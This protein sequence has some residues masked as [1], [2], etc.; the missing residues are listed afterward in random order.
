MCNSKH[1]RNNETTFAILVGI[2]NYAAVDD[3]GAL[4]GAV[5]DARLFKQY[6]TD[7][8][9]CGGLQVPNSHIQYLE[10][11]NATRSAII[12]TLDSH[13]LN[14]PA[15]LDHGDTTLIFYFAGHG[16]RVEAPGNI[17]AA[18]GKIEVLCP[19]DERT[20]GPDGEYVHGIPDYVLG[21]LLHRI[22]EKKGNNMSV[23]LDSCHSGGMGRLEDTVRN[24]KIASRPIP[25]ELD[26]HLWNDISTTRPYNVWSSSA[27]S[28]VLLAACSQDG[29]AYETSSEPFHGR[30]T[31][32]LVAELRRAPLENTTYADII[33]SLPLFSMQVPHCGGANRDRLLFRM[34][35]PVAGRR[36][37]ALTEQLSPSESG[38]NQKKTSFLVSIGSVEGVCPGTEFSVHNSDNRIL[39]T[40]TARI[41]NTNQT[42]LYVE[43]DK[44][45]EIPR[46]SR[47][48]VKDWKNNAKVLRVYSRD[49]E[50]SLAITGT[51]R[52]YVQANSRESANLSLK[53][54]GDE[55][56]VEWLTGPIVACARELRLPLKVEDIP[57]PLHLPSLLDGISHFHFFLERENGST[58]LPNFSLEMHRLLGRYP[59]RTPDRSV[60]AD[61]N[62][63]VGGKVEFTSNQDAEYGFTMRNTSNVD[64]FPYLFYFN[65]LKYTIKPW[66]IPESA[67]GRPPLHAFGSVAVG[68]GGEGAFSFTLPPGTRSSSGFVKMFVSTQYLSL[69]WIKQ[70]VPP[71]DPHFEGSGRLQ[72]ARDPET[73]FGWNALRVLLTMTQP[74]M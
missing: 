5:N 58:L 15:I 38:E 19:S 1:P 60:G 21:Q 2:N 51:P 72:M 70:P 3:F 61:G 23:I 68:L 16:S 22:A 28:H 43:D 39:C 45:V 17:L 53:R 11:G 71:F 57:R 10:N 41:V 63:I 42:V 49:F 34:A 30:F 24:V 8:R 48:L 14:N 74:E 47:A 73:H 13:F 54:E 25:F 36:A 32:S 62:L 55:L 67:H 64:L 18:D 66:Y 46:G 31:H 52:D 33:D 44:Y 12:S 69:A 56:V 9:D 37:M 6:L 7:P 40:L 20:F 26:S 27:Y 35:Y 59:R 29:M 50:A 65:P 4:R